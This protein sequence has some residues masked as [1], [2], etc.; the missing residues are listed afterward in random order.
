MDLFVCLF[1]FVFVFENSQE[2]SLRFW[3]NFVKQKST[4]GNR[5][6]TAVSA[7][8]LCLALC[9]LDV[10]RNVGM[11]GTSVYY[12]LSPPFSAFHL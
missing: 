4:F 10:I 7:A 1:V 5:E 2:F 6:N 9:A 8:I 11:S 12:V 3:D